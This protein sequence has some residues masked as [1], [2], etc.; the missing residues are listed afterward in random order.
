MHSMGVTDEDR[1][2]YRWYGPWASPAPTE[3]ALIL[4]G[5]SVPW[6][7]VGGWAIEAWTGRH[8][9]HDDIDIGFFRDDLAAVLAHLSPSFCVWSNL[10][11]TIR[12]LNR[13]E[14]LLEGCR[15][16][17][18]RRD[19]ATPWLLDLAMTPRD[20]GSW[21][22]PRDDALR[23]PFDEAVFTSADGIRYLR[24]ELVLAFRARS[25]VRHAERDFEATVPSLDRSSRE[26]LSA[27]VRRIDA[28][29]PWLDRLG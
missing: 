15:Q 3:A 13:P 5:L 2:F 10:G 6:W 8:R 9:E 28:N 25:M 26:R 24:P 1:D 11:G 4:S 17:W 12:P 27:A 18:V 29:H 22:S 19:G 7:I 20:D 14:D 23:V 16:L 21:V